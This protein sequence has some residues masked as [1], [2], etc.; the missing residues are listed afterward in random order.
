MQSQRIHST[1]A[2]SPL[3]QLQAREAM[4][5]HFSKYF[6]RRH[7]WW[8]FPWSFFKTNK[9]WTLLFWDM[10]LLE[11]ISLKNDAGSPRLRWS[12]MPHGVLQSRA[13]VQCCAALRIFFATVRLVC[14][15]PLCFALK[16]C[17][18]LGVLITF[19]SRGFF[20]GVHC[21]VFWCKHCFV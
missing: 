2:R 18:C 9:W 10:I 7:V 6:F 20:C 4:I 14:E 21:V 16:G 11:R 3:R 13:A 12:V 1:Y 8:V 5:P 17:A 19:C 15:V